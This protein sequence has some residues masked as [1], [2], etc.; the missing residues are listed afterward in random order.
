MSA[1]PFV[2]AERARPFSG[3]EASARRT[4]SARCA[5]VA[6]GTL[7]GIDAAEAPEE[8]VERPDRAAEE[9]AAAAEQVA[10]DAVD[11][12]RVRHDQ[13]RF[14]VE[15]RQI[16][17]QKKRDFARMRRPREEGQPHL[18]IVER[19]QDVSLR[20]LTTETAL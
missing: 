7:L 19:P 14:V 4:T 20:P 2:R 12:R 9:A 5:S 17:L 1:N 3:A 15:A 18:P 10:L 16:A 6:T 13:C 8:V 11:V